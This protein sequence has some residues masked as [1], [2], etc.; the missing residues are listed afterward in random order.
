MTAP[1]VESAPAS[2]PGEVPL[3]GFDALMKN[4][5]AQSYWARRLVAYVIDVLIVY[6]VLAIIG[7]AVALPLFLLSGGSFL[8][9][10]GGYFLVLS[11][12]IQFLYFFV[13]EMAIGSTIG[14]RFLGLRV[15]AD[16][17]RP[18]NGAEAAIRNVSKI[19]WVLLLLDVVVG[20]ATS[21]QYTKKYSD[22]LAHTSVVMA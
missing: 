20:L 3:S 6:V 2:F 11:G 7:W 19:H 18:P 1:R 21:K 5:V 17:G 16:E 9:V 13:A 14:K 8:S 15:A 12:V 22:T 4:S 10:F